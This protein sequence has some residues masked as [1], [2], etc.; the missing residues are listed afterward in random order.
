VNGPPSFL[1]FIFVNGLL[2]ISGGSSGER[3]LAAF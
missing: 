3:G 1:I 2:H